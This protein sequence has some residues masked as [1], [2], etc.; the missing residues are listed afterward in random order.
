MPK[1][2]AKSARKDSAKGVQRP[3]GYTQEQID[4]AIAA[5]DEQAGRTPPCILEAL[6]PDG[7][8]IGG[9]AV[10]PLTIASYALLE[11]L[12]NPVTE[13]KGLEAMTNDQLM[14]LC[15]VLTRPV[16]ECREVL[17][18]GPE[19]WEEAYLEFGETLPM[20][21]VVEIGRTIGAVIAQA[22]ATFIPTQAKKKATASVPHSKRKP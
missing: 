10:V 2:P 14:E 16:R 11:K 12:G 20:E 3:R 1:R 13:P 21:Q 19:A 22:T 18:D 4:A 5:R 7:A 8:R 17:A 9:C 15:Y 6:Y